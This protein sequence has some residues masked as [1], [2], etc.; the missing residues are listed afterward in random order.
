[1][2]VVIDLNKLIEVTMLFH[3]GIA[4]NISWCLVILLTCCLVKHKIIFFNLTENL[5]KGQIARRYDIQHKDTQ[6]YNIQHTDSQ[7][8]D[9]Q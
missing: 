4:H 7:N 9:S 3:L 5:L 6:R 1:M 8:S 2:Y